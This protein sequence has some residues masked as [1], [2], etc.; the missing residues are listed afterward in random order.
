MLIT[1]HPQKGIGLLAE[2]NIQCPGVRMRAPLAGLIGLIL[3]HALT[4]S[5]QE[6]PKPTGET[7]VAPGVKLE[8]VFTRSAPIQGGLT[9]GPTSA[10]DGSIYFSDIPVGMDKGLIMRFD[11]KTGQ[12]TVFVDDSRKSNGLKIGPEGLLYACEGS[13]YGGR[14]LVRWNLET[15]ERTVLAETYQGKR[16]NAPNDLVVD[17]HGR[18]YFSDPRYLG[19]EPREL[20]HR[21][22]YRWEPDGKVIEVTHEVEKPNGLAL[23]P[24]GM[25]LYLADHNNGTDRIDGDS[26]TPPLRGAMKIYAFPLGRDGLINGPR[27]TLVDFEDQA[28]CDGMTVDSKGHIYLTARSL[29]RPG[30]LVIDPTGQEIAFI[31]TG[32]PNQP[33]S[34]AKGLPSN[35]TFGAGDDRHT[36]YITVDVS[37]YRISLRVPGFSPFPRP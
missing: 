3:F 7:I 22:V 35:V 16:F 31:P 15:R 5:A 14:A 1:R 11:P 21:A 28:G 12:T 20:E 23:S 30:V 25:T 4:V 34:T 18:V 8:R 13:D 17:R 37:L 26:K 27:K 2:L 10:P 36:L 24:D 9:E 29:K 32:T 19:P 33:E 6:I